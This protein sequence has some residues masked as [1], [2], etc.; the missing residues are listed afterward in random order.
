MRV[1]DL[2]KRKFASFQADD[3]LDHMIE[4]FSEK[5]ITSAPVFSKDEFIG[6]V[7]C[8]DLAK[9]F[10]TRDRG[11]IPFLEGGAVDWSSLIAAKLAKK[12]Q[13]F[14]TP[15]QPV[16]LVLSKIASSQDC[17]PVMSESKVIGFV[18]PESILGFYL[19][20]RVKED[21][22]KK[23]AKSEPKGAAVLHDNSTT[24]DSM[25]EIVKREGKTTPKKLAAELGIT[26]ET[27][28]DL[29]VLLGKHKLVE[30]NYSFLTGM[31]LQRID[32]GRI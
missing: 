27:A 24:I 14:L 5:G 6:I 10:Q 25:L 15:D 31:T 22:T 11:S 16:S 18:W 28:E 13:F 3:S 20:E 30:I 9:F 17:I 21:A 7:N 4:A 8:F 1:Q 29:A 32:H 19:A 2:M 12:P 26:V 23:K